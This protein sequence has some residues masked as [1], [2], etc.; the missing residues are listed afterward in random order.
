MEQSPTDVEYHFRLKHES[1]VYL[2]ILE[3]TELSLNPFA[4]EM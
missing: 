2:C 4:M 1:E 3:S